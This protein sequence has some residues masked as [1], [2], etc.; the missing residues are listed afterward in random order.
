MANKA[1]D[2][3]I[4]VG[5]DRIEEGQTGQIDRG[6]RTP[7]KLTP[8]MIPVGGYFIPSTTMAWGR[9]VIDGKPRANK[10]MISPT[11]NDYKGEIE[12][13]KWGHPDG[14]KILVQYLDGCSS[15]DKVYQEKRL[16]MLPSNEESSIELQQGENRFNFDSEETKINFLKITSAN[17]NSLSKDHTKIKGFVFRELDKDDEYNEKDVLKIASIGRAINVVSNIESK[18]GELKVLYDILGGKEAIPEVT[19]R[20]N[21][22]QIYPALMKFAAYKESEFFQKIEEY[23]RKVSD[24][25]SKAESY[26]LLDLTL[27]GSIQLSIDGKKKEILKDIPTKGDA[28]KDWVMENYT[29]ADVAQMIQT[30]EAD[31][32]KIK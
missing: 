21:E 10:S 26:Q 4:S 28:M 31:L 15:F 11:D 27:N 9:R 1:T 24:M 16:N 13:L 8:V 6:T 12:F 18:P 32:K 23:K 2:Y 5:R 14:E 19:D 25:F 22:F 30:L 20:K 7:N 29:N 17:K 3:V